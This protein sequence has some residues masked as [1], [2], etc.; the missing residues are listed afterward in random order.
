MFFDAHD[1]HTHVPHVDVIFQSPREEN[2]KK[3]EEVK[4]RAEME[5]MSKL[6]EAEEKS[7]KMEAERMAAKNKD[8]SDDD[9]DDLLDDICIHPSHLKKPEP[10]VT[11]EDARRASEK[12]AK[13]KGE[14]EKEKR[15]KEKWFTNS[16]KG[17]NGEG[18]EDEEEDDGKFSFYKVPSFSILILILQDALVFICHFLSSFYKVPSL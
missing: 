7:R 2:E 16:D 8:D 9:L 13:A 15:T 1:E 10:E 3:M 17:E 14:E 4:K 12:F 6:K 18:G 11:E 5:Q